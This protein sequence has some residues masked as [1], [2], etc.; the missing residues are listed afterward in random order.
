MY[1]PA[2]PGLSRPTPELSLRVRAAIAERGVGLA[3][4]SL[5]ISRDSLL[6]I[7]CGAHV[8]KGSLA[9]AERGL[10]QSD[11]DQLAT[12]VTP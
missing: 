9:L 6:M 12:V 10:D 8:T 11:G 1:S 2:R 4:E 3:A 5:G 7:G